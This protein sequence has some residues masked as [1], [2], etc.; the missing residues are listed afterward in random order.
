[1]FRQFLWHMTYILAV[2]LTE[3]SDVYSIL[4]GAY[5][6][7]INHTACG[8]PLCTCT[9][10]FSRK[11]SS[12]PDGTKSLDP[13]RSQVVKKYVENHPKCHHVFPPTWGIPPKNPQVEHLPRAERPAPAAAAGP[14]GPAGPG[15]RGAKA[16]AETETEVPGELEQ[17]IYGEFCGWSLLINAVSEYNIYNIYIIYIY[18]W[19]S[20]MLETIIVKKR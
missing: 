18:T 3:S 11:R 6:N 20:W 12:E 17:G 5:I 8:A 7:G 9:K 19:I 1:M 14:A 4:L 2:S 16:M 10:V 13:H 15:S